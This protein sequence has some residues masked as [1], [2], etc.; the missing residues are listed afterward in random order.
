MTFTLAPFLL[1]VD[2]GP[3]TGFSTAITPKMDRLPQEF[4]TLIAQAHLVDLSGLVADWSGSCQALK[5]L[6]I[7]KPIRLGS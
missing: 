5:G 3:R 2:L 4:V 6:G 1:V 7:G